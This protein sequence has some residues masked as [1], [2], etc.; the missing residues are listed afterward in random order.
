MPARGDSLVVTYVAW[1]FV[2]QTGRT[3]DATNHS[4]KLLLDG[5]ELVPSGNPA[6]IDSN[7]LPGMYNLAVTSAETQCSILVVCGVSSSSGVSIIQT[8]ISLT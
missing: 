7:G 3:G 4:L 1:D 2:T 5:V 6:E 8:S